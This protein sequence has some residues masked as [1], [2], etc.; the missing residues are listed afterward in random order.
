MT[1]TAIIIG[2]TGV[3]GRETVKQTLESSYYD[4]VV[5]FTR[6]PIETPE[7]VN[8]HKLTQHIVNFDDISQ[9]QNLITGDDLY[10]CIGTTLKQAGSKETQ[11]QIDLNYPTTI[12]QFAK[13]N[14]VQSFTLVSS[15]GAN[16]ESNSFYLR[17]KGQLERNI[18]Q[19]SFKQF[20]LIRPS[21]IV[22]ERSEFRIGELILKTA[23]KMLA[24][25]PGI[26]KYRAITGKEIAKRMIIA[27]TSNS[28]SQTFALDE[29]FID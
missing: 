9:W 24:W 21:L 2:A 20:I 5:T 17:L 13:Q 3:V 4:K 8:N 11:T 7:L 15:Y 23:L 25:L 26:R 6:R 29:V 1:K 27:T 19:L 14:N 10:C 16:V 18:H 22:G 28:G 12:A